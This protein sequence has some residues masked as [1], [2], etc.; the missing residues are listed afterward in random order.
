MKNKTTGFTL[1]EILIALFIFAIVAAITSSVLYSVFNARKQTLEHSNQLA[2]LQLATTL[3]RQDFSQ[4][5]NYSF[6]NKDGSYINAVIAK[7]SYIEF[8]RSIPAK[9]ATDN[10]NSSLQRVAYTLKQKQLVRISWPSLQN[11]LATT[12]DEKILF[13]NVEQLEIGYLSYGQGFAMNWPPS[14]IPPAVL[15]INRGIPIPKAVS[16]TITFVNGQRLNL[17]YLI[18]SSAINTY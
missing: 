17:I 6:T 18:P 16:L 9:L 14:N 11:V 5:I 2:Q 7:P 10:Q 15:L 3:M 1:I 12:G 4:M 13:T 8:T